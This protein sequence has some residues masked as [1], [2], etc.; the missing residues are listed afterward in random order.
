MDKIRTCTAK[1]L[2]IINRC[3][4]NR[5]NIYIDKSQMDKIRAL[6]I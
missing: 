6:H 4:R 3:K 5:K 2:Y 1:Q